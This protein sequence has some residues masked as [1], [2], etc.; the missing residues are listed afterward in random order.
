MAENKQEKR[1]FKYGDREYL[2]DD[3]LKLHGEQENSYYDFAKNRGQYDDTALQGLRAAI[4]NRI[5]AVKNG[6]AFDGD[7]VMEG[8]VV[9]NTTI[10]TK[11]RGLRKKDKYVDQDNTEWAK[12]YLNKLVG[13]LKPYEVESSKNG[14]WDMGKYGLAA[15]LTGQGLD[16]KSIFE[17]KDLRD[18]NNPEAARAFTQ[19][20]EMLRSYLGGYKNWLTGKGFDFTKNDNEWDD[21]FV[22]TLD[23][24]INNKD[25][26][27][28][29]ALAA[30]LRKLGA[31]N[32][33]T[34]AFTSDKWDLSKSAEEIISDNKKIQEEK[35]KKTKIKEYNDTIDNYYNV[36]STLDPKSAQM[37]SFLGQQHSNFYRSPEEVLEWARNNKADMDG[38]QKRYNENPWDVEAAQYILPLMQANGVLK[39]AEIDGVKY[40]YDPRKINRGNHTF[41]AIDP[42]TGAMEQKFLYDIDQEINQLKSRYMKPQGSSKYKI[43]VHEKG[44][45]LSMQNGGEF[46]AV[47]YLKTLDSE[48]YAKRA[49]EKGISERELKEAERTPFGE[50]NAIN[51][52]KFTTNDFVQIGTMAGNI[53]SIF[54]DPI[55]GGLTG[56]GLSTV[57][58]VNDISRD[59]FQMKDVGNYVKNVGMDFIGMLPIIGDTFGTLG[60]VK[61]GLIQL[62]PKIIG[63]FGMAQGIANSPQIIDSFSKIV[64]DRDMTTADWH[65]IATGLNLIVSGSRV[66]R[67]ALKNSA[68]KK[69]SLESDKLQV[70]V[71]DGKNTKLLVLDG[72]N[73]K[74]VKNSD[75]SVKAVNDIINNIDGMQNYKVTAKSKVFD[76]S[77]KMPGRK[78]KDSSTGEDKRIWNPF[79]AKT[80]EANISAVYDPVTFARTYAN[81]ANFGIDNLKS[82]RSA[83]TFLSGYRSTRKDTVDASGKQNLEQFK[84]QQT[85]LEE[86][87]IQ[88][89]R[90]SAKAYADAK[91]KSKAK[92]PSIEA[93]IDKARKI[94]EQTITKGATE[95]QALLDNEKLLTEIDVIKDARQKLAQLQSEAQLLPKGKRK[96]TKE[97]AVRKQAKLVEDLQQKLDDL[98]NS[99]N[100]FTTKEA[101]RNITNSTSEIDALTI[102]RSRLQDLISR[103]ETRKADATSRYASNSPAFNDLLNYTQK[104]VMFNGKTYKIGPDKSFTKEALLEEGLFKQGGSINRNKIN[105]FLNYAK[106]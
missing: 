31:G 46:N 77:I 93:G 40:V 90:D 9:D 65:N 98:Q 66:G 4:T 86:A 76:Y 79:E 59:G 75:H 5:S 80:K 101:Q 6:Q 104:E 2:L 54:M 13:Q 10:K 21:D 11:N 29:L 78:G 17:G 100:I 3:L 99:L 1:T 106:G 47:E 71:T 43:D 70:E 105:K 102:Q 33:Y 25:W 30:S 88:S 97:K 23:A 32:E 68:A 56:A 87:R 42:D 20:D 18:E 52:S 60:K 67:H 69:A 12:Y 92:I 72:E 81:T 50:K 89:L 22:A 74:A 28:R 16:A 41:I 19:R 91:A 53:A 63:Y 49:K 14:G 27:D 8:D 85:E 103:L 35:D 94:E 96:K 45:I 62:A 34:T 15:Y 26:N 64:D 44:G 61:K 39:E 84:K 51:N 73:A 24:V 48:D 37:T 38:Y 36:Y 55:S 58:F 83:K 57:D 82:T 95:A 7:G